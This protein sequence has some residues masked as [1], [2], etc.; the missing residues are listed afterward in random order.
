MAVAK[1]PFAAATSRLLVAQI[2]THSEN[3]NC[4]VEMPPS[5]QAFEIIQLAH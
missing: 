1:N 4:A 2:P 3:D 5:E